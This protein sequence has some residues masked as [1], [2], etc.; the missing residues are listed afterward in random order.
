M[1]GSS[2]MPVHS[3]IPHTWGWPKDK[4]EHLIKKKLLSEIKSYNSP[5]SPQNI[6]YIDKQTAD[7]NNIYYRLVERI[8]FRYNNNICE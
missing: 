7:G 8:F 6:K 1:E 3:A 2:C 5:I 4:K